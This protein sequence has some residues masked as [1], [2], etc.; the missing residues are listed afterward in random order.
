ME[1]GL[2]QGSR[3]MIANVMVL[4]L[5]SR[6]LERTIGNQLPPRLCPSTLIPRPLHRNKDRVWEFR[7]LFQGLEGLGLSSW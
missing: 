6:S 1:T 5:F 7:E 3:A 2:M 4:G